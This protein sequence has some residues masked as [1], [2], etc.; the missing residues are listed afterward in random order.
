MDERLP[1][2]RQRA[3]RLASNHGDHRRSSECFD[4]PEKAQSALGEGRGELLDKV[5]LRSTTPLSRT[6]ASP[7]A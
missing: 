6:Q 2:P 1:L 5:E 3:A 4:L 7:G